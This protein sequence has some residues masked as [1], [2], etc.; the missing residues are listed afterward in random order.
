[1]ARAQLE[2]LIKRFNKAKA[3]QEPWLSTWR[4]GYRYLLPQR[5][6]LDNPRPGQVKGDEVFDS[7]AVNSGQKFA[8][9]LVDALFPPYQDFVKF[10]PGPGVPATL[11]PRVLQELQK[12]QKHFH[13]AIW[14][15][16]FY[17]SVSESAL[18]LLLGTGVMLE[19]EGPDNDP[20]NFESVPLPTAILEAGPRGRHGALFREHKLAVRNI[21]ATWPDIEN[22]PKDWADKEN[23]DPDAEVTVI[24]ATYPDWGLEV[25]YYD[26]FSPDLKVYLL[27]QPRVFADSDPWLIFRWARANNEVYGRGPGLFALADV[28]TANKVVELILK[29]ASIAISG[30]YTGVDDGVLNP[31]TAQFVPGAII[32]VARNQGHPQGA[33]LTPLE[34][35]GNFD[36][37]QLVLEDLRMAIKGAMMDRTLPPDTGPV[38]SATEIVERIK[39]L[40]I[41]I[42][43]AFGRIMKEL[44]VPLVMRTLKILHK[45]GVITFPLEIDGNNIAVE[46]VSPVARQQTMAELEAVV[47]WLQLLSLLG[48]EMIY[49]SAKVEGMGA[50]M[51]EKL[52]VDQTLVR[53]EKDRAIIQDQIAKAMQN[54]AQQQP[55]QA[56][57]LAGPTA[58][59]GNAAPPGGPIQ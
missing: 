25:W 12:V 48:P 33:S 59:A 5:D 27:D 23:D 34:R 31:S 38:R 21:K 39:E 55:G 46:I 3:R 13:A 17:S 52:G 57:G 56:G 32:P 43:P 40:Q 14:R 58:L 53:D 4:D 8:H 36:V 37:A 28:R 1:M 18:D 45:K 15:S 29:N 20:L 44:I 11:R 10:E 26:L 49:F 7:T 2:D 30:V 51:A 50:W 35:S 9:R 19:M 6:I 41:D 22:L 54:M 24:E 16:N 42:G 47:Q